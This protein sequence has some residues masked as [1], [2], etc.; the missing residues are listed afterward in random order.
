MSRISRFDL[1]DSLV[2]FFLSSGE[3]PTPDSLSS[4]VLLTYPFAYPG[5][6]F[7]V[8]RFETLTGAASSTDIR[9]TAV[10]E[11][12]FEFSHYVAASTDDTSNMIINLFL[13]SASSDLVAIGV[14]ESIKLGGKVLVSNVIV[15]PG[16]RLF[17][18]SDG[19]NA[20]KFMFLNRVFTTH[21]IGTP[22]L[23]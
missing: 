7:D 19:I 13:E 9:S 2:S 11:G 5:A 12:F 6:N 4:E 8:L 21:K 1:T 20:G 22:V 10:A 23:R 17:A 3:D 18:E 16:A 15:P 14:D